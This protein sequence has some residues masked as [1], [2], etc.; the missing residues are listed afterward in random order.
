MEYYK[1]ELAA[2][3]HTLFIDYRYN[4]NGYFSSDYSSGEEA[5]CRE[6]DKNLEL[7]TIALEPPKPESFNLRIGDM[8]IESGR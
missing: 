5:L 2:N 1:E 7:E 6:L 8:L 4:S 3:K